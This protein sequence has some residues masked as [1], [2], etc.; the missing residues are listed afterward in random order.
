MLS[1]STDQSC[2][3]LNQ[4]TVGALGSLSEHPQEYSVYPILISSTCKK[5][6]GAEHA[7]VIATMLSAIGKTKNS[8]AAV[9]H[10]VSIASDG[11]SKH[12]DAL[13]LLT[14]QKHLS[15]DSAIYPQLHHLELMNHLVGNDDVTADKDFKHV[16]KCQQNLLMQ[17]KGIEI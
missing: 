5:E 1:C 14:M 10:T 8:R 7:R 12:G 6:T 16:F 13:V 15:P 11:E 4:A 2:C 3:H 17:N 9:Y